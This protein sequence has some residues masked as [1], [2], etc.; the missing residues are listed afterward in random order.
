MARICALFLVSVCCL[1]WL[2]PAASATDIL[3]PSA[4]LRLGK[5]L[6][7]P[8][9]PL[10]GPLSSEIPGDSADTAVPPSQKPQ[11][12]PVAVPEPGSMLLMG[13]CAFAVYAVLSIRPRQR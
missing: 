12:Q 4:D 11:Q 2:T 10:P 1:G 3:A 13:V 6:A 5:E 8:I 7:P 9:Q